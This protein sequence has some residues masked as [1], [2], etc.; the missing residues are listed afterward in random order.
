MCLPQH[1]LSVRGVRPNIDDRLSTSDDEPMRMHVPDAADGCGRAAVTTR[2]RDE[3][4]RGFLRNLYLAS[5]AGDVDAF[6]KVMVLNVTL[7]DHQR[8]VLRHRGFRR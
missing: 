6:P 3:G 5:F 4:N 7:D 8:R 1:R 2:G